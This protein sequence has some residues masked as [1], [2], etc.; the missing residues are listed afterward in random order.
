M[1][2]YA[3]RL[4][5]STDTAP[6]VRAGDALGRLPNGTVRGRGGLRNDGGGVVSVVGGTM[7]VSVS[8][9]SCWVD[10]DE[11]GQVGFLFV[12]DD[13]EVLAVSPG[14]ASLDRTDVVAVVVREDLYDGSGSTTATLEVVEGTPGAGTPALPYAAVP[15]RNI[16]VPA[17]T[18]VGT[19][20]LTAGNLSTDR[21]VFTVADGGVL[22]VASATER[23][24]L[25][26]PQAGW[27]VYREDGTLQVYD[28]AAW[29]TFIPYD[30]NAVQRVV[31]SA[32]ESLTST[33]TMQDDDELRFTVEAGES[34]VFDLAVLLSHAS[35]SGVDAKVGFTFPSGSML[36]MA[37][38]MDPSATSGYD[39]QGKWAGQNQ[40]QTSGG[41]TVTV[42]VAA[43]IGSTDGTTVLIK[44]SFVA[45]ASGT[46]KLRWAPNA[47]SGTPMKLK[48]GSFLVAERV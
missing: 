25:T 1:T 21:R 11:A 32:D 30:A 42:G 15:L 19:G 35:S 20:G 17:N 23:D 45:S 4:E 33:T 13:T 8:P 7:S 24:A 36:F 28:G 46:V 44:G 22:P 3:L 38:G 6:R 27:T 31:K 29:S 18:S 16:T 47:S 14:H 2:G 26:S 43:Q 9:L 37:A 12:S 5:S 48:A 40:T 10:A 39:N 34:Y 41:S